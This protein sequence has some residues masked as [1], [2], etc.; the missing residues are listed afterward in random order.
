MFSG[1]D[2]HTK[3][4]L[5]GNFMLIICC[6]FYIAWWLIAFHPT[7]AVKGMKSGW[8]LI[9][10]FIFG[11]WGVVQVANGSSTG[12]EVPVIIPKAGIVIGAIAAY[13]V[14]FVGTYMLMHRQVTTELFLIVGWT[15]LMLMELDTL[16][17]LGEFRETSAI[18]LMVVTVLAAVVS[19]VC[20]LLYYN[21]D[22]VKG[23]IDGTIPLGLAG[24][25]MIVISVGV[26]IR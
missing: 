13:L 23:Y 7:H 1:L 26:V 20:Y 3:Q 24:I 14:L 2:T 15:A 5:T 18:L 22:A 11:V 10:A 25:M 6:I 8:L 19:M 21:L 9:P 16:Y 12:E 17:G 4:I